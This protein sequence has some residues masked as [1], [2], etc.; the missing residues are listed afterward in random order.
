MKEDNMEKCEWKDGKFKPCEAGSEDYISLGNPHD[1]M[2]SVFKRGYKVNF[3]PFCGTDIRKPKSEQLT[4]KERIKNHLKRIQTAIRIFGKNSYSHIE[5][6]SDGLEYILKKE[7]ED[8]YCPQCNS[9]NYNKTTGSCPN[10]GY[11][12]SYVL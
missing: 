8:I 10:C 9:E 6:L 3:C 7:S 4:H 11:V 1:G 12:S 5:A 2:H